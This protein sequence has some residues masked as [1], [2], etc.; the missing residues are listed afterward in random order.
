MYCIFWSILTA[1]ARSN[2]SLPLTD[3]Q[4]DSAVIGR[5][6]VVSLFT[7]SALSTTREGDYRSLSNTRRWFMSWIVRYNCV[8]ESPQMCFG[9]YRSVASIS[10]SSVGS[11]PLLGR[12]L[13][14]IPQIH[15]NTNFRFLA[16]SETR[17][18]MHIFFYTYVHVY[19]HLTQIQM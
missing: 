2:I 17:Y 15:V 10:R 13:K 16:W 8:V 4:P 3:W 7:L 19:I 9:Y 5:D 12:P 11:I 18:A 6:L 14:L 1:C